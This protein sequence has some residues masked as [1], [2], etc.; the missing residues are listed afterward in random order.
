[1]A[2]T[3]G[4]VVPVPVGPGSWTEAEYEDLVVAAMPSM[5]AEAEQTVA[6]PEPEPEK[7]AEPKP[8]RV[9]SKCGHEDGNSV[10]KIKL[11]R[12]IEVERDGM[13][14]LS[15]EPTCNVCVGK[16]PPEE[17]RKIA[18]IGYLISVVGVKNAA[19]RASAAAMAY[20]KS[21]VDGTAEPLQ[22]RRDKNGKVLCGVP[23]CRLCRDTLATR[24]A[25]VKTAEGKYEVAGICREQV[26]ALIKAG[27]LRHIHL[28]DYRGAQMEVERRSKKA[29]GENTLPLKTEPPAPV[30]AEPAPAS[31]P[32]GPKPKL[33][34]AERE[35]RRW[36]RRRRLALDVGN[37]RFGSGKRHKGGQKGQN[38][39]GKKR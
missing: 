13:R 30:V 24:F 21:V 7:P 9:C 32:S 33:S 8:R 16:M 5:T 17:K 22:V 26:A 27:A 11:G 6:A 31:Q 19:I 28:F 4:I 14:L 10:G 39:G 2:G 20:W 15:I 29:G 3:T 35:A 23:N 12:I 18:K 1:M 37:T 36:E 34:R 25:I 38:G